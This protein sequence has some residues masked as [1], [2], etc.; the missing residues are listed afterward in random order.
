MSQ[1][2]EETDRPITRDADFHINFGAVVRAFE[3]LLAAFERAEPAFHAFGKATRAFGSAFAK[4]VFSA[5]IA[6]WLICH[7]LEPY[8]LSQPDHGQQLLESTRETARD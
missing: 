1:T 5:A 7:A 8:L 2:E 4:I 6:F 3:Q